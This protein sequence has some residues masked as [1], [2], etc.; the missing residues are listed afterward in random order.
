MSHF[1]SLLPVVGMPSNSLATS[2]AE[3]IKFGASILSIEELC[4]IIFLF[5]SRVDLNLF[6]PTGCDSILFIGFALRGVVAP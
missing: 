3:F 6:A 2:S 1:D 4:V 5:L